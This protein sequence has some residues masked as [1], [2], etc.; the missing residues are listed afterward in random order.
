MVRW[1][2]KRQ[3]ISSDLSVGTSQVIQRVT[4]CVYKARDIAIVFLRL[5]TLSLCAAVKE[6]LAGYVKNWRER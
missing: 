6:G 4:S 1:P 3:P 2:V 5:H